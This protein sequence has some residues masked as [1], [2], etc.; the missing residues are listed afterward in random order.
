M[1]N[2]FAFDN[3]EEYLKF[4]IGYFGYIIVEKSKVKE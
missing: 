3:F 2:H 1:I 4:I